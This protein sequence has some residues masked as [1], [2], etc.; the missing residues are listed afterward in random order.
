MLGYSGM[1]G[2]FS[3]FKLKL[4]EDSR[5]SMAQ[6][7]VSLSNKIKIIQ[8]THLLNA[9]KAMKSAAAAPESEETRLFPLCH[10]ALI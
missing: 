4:V 2:S 6:E 7:L 3:K 10:C 9:I 5:S 1:Y 8:E